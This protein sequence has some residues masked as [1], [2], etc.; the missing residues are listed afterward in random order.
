MKKVC[1]FILLLISLFILCSCSGKGQQTD[2]TSSTSTIVSD[3]ISSSIGNENEAKYDDLVIGENAQG[4][5]HLTGQLTS[6]ILVD[7][8]IISNCDLETP[9]TGY[10]YSGNI[11]AF[12]DEARNMFVSDNLTLIGS[13][14][15]QCGNSSMPY[16]G[17]VY[18]DTYTDINGTV[19]QHTVFPDSVVWYSEHGFSIHGFAL[20]VAKDQ[21]A[22]K[23]FSFASEKEAYEQAAAVLVTAGIPVSSCYQVKRL[24]YDALESEYLISKSYGEDVSVADKNLPNGWT[25]K[26]NAYL[27]TMRYEL[28]EFPVSSG[29]WLGYLMCD[30]EIPSSNEDGTILYGPAIEVLVTSAGVEFVQ[31]SLYPVNSEIETEG[32]MCSMNQALDAFFLAL[33]SPVQHESLYYMTNYDDR[34]LTIANIELSYVCFR[35]S[36][37]T[38][39]SI[40]PCWQIKCIRNAN[41]DDSQSGSEFA[42]AYI[43]A[44]TGEYINTT[45]SNGSD[46]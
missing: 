15:S 9:G 38:E 41:K 44:L 34:E 4:Q 45:T 43:N 22:S 19:Y 18:R 32:Q 33:Q 29:G 23:D 25:E 16:S 30:E 36:I 21:L 14:S 8:D 28:E 11:P 37:E 7:A 2:G 17:T 3:S 26:E 5:P 24:S 1:I 42:W 6:D 10:T 46:M 12:S 31:T 20:N 13:E 35:D 40:V 39:A 27:F